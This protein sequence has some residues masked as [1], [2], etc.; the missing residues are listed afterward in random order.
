MKSLLALLPGL[1]VPT[2]LAAQPAGARRDAPRSSDEAAIRRVIDAYVETWNRHDMDAWGQLF[3][4]DVDYVNRGGGWWRSNRDNVEGHRVIHAG[5]VRRGDRADL[6]ARVASV[7]LLA[8]DVALVHVQTRLRTD[9][10]M[11]AGAERGSA[12][13]EG[14][15]PGAIMT[16]VM[17][18]RDE[19]WLIRALQNTL[20]DESRPRPPQPP[21][22]APE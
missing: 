2:V 19:R 18:R 11:A 14:W 13:G 5:I 4:E 1:L 9:P 7:S 8:D 22:E 15:A 3:T 10:A 17:V 12:D 20:V 6:E 16:V 21:R